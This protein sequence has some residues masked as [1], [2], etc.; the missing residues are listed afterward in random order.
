MLLQLGEPLHRHFLGPVIGGGQA[1]RLGRKQRGELD[2][3]DADAQVAAPVRS[4]C[5]CNSGNPF[6]GISLVQSSA[7][8]R[9][10]GLG[11]NSAANSTLPMPMRRSQAFSQVQP[12]CIAVETIT[13][14][15]ATAGRGSSAQRMNVCVP[16]PLAP[17]TAT[18]CGSTSGRLVRKSSARIESHVCKP[19][20]L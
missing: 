20:M 4:K 13:A 19:M 18:R 11:A 8:V 3:A 15:K 9:P 2:G 6:T 1:E 12:P 5:C 14:G 10:S 17:V 16:P 7:A